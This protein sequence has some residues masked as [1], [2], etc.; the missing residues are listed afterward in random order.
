MLKYQVIYRLMV[1]GTLIVMLS[2]SACGAL[3]QTQG[4]PTS[5]N[6]TPDDA[7][8]EGVP[9]TPPEDAA[10]GSGGR[11]YVE[12]VELTM[13]ES[14]PVQV[15]AQIKG[16]LS[17]GCTELVAVKTEYDETSQTFIIAVETE[18]DPDLMCT[19]ALVPFEETVALEVRG[20]RAG[21]YMVKAQD[22]TADFTLAVDNV[23]PDE[24]E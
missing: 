17:D 4:T 23:L 24:T 1:A 5:P 6:G 10:G 18:R 8:E 19:Q 20:L 21:T 11:A 12:D 2:L 3:G 13:L 16:Q 22:E 15:R 7:P 14:F 9:E